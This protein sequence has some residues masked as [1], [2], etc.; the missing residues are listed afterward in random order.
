MATGTSAV[1]SRNSRPP[2]HS[3]VTDRTYSTGYDA[4][5][6]RF[7]ADHPEPALP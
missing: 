5:A 4:D 2:S 7:L 1:T 3:S 6:E